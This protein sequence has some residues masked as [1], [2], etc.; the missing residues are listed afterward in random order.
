MPAMR[1]NVSTWMI[2]LG[3]FLLLSTGAVVAGEQSAVM[4]PTG[5]I[6]LQNDSARLALAP[7]AGYTALR[8]ATARTSWPTPRAAR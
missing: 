7:T 3:L 4:S 8:G 2:L 6:I 5:E 1:H